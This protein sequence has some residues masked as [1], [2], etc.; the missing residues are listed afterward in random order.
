MYMVI[1]IAVN[2]G[3]VPRRGRRFDVHI[4]KHIPVC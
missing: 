2:P 1:Y 4:E 3:R